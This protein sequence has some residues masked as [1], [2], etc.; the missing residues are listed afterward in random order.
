MHGGAKTA[1]YVAGGL[2][3]LLIITL[4]VGLWIIIRA[5]KARVELRQ[6]GLVQYGLTTVRMPFAEM[7]RIGVLEIP[8]VAR[9]IGGALARKKCGGD[10]GINFCM[11]NARGKTKKFVASMYENYGD[12]MNRT[13]QAR[14]LPLEKMTMGTFKLEWPDNQQAPAA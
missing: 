10:R 12:F 4:P 9:G 14:Q 7:A 11:M 5:A 2:L 1:Y 3:C 8:I 13:S 6:D